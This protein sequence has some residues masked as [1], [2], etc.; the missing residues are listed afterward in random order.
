[1]K[2]FK[3]RRSPRRVGTGLS[4]ILVF[5][6]LGLLGYSLWFE[7]LP[8]LQAYTSPKESPATLDEST[9]MELTIPRMDLE[10]LQVRSTPV[11]DS[12]ALDTGAQHVEGTGLPWEQGTNTYI[13][14][15]RIGYPGTDSY[16]VFYDLDALQNGDEVILTDAD[17]TEY[18]YAVFTSFTV[19]PSDYEV[20]RPVPGKSVV[21]L[22]TCTLPDYSERFVVQ[23]ELVSV[24]DE[25]PQEQYQYDV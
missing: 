25:Q 4:V 17:G 12:S 1:M 18:T 8:M 23:A 9:T 14:G 16:L 21:S 13:A 11:S 2:R 6:G 7:A 20:T 15:H 3:K 19:G 10:G 22:Q 24:S 5:V